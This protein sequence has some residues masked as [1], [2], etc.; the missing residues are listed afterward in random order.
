MA[1][2]FSCFNNLLAAEN[3]VKRLHRGF[4]NALWEWDV[5]WIGLGW[6]MLLTVIRNTKREVVVGSKHRYRRRE[7]IGTL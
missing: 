2:F 4:L 6:A 1:G 5:S 3:L 7:E